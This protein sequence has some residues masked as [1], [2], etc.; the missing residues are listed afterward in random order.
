M[1]EVARQRTR[2]AAEL[3]RIPG[4]TPSVLRRVGSAI[5]SALDGSAP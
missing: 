4:I 2:G 5:L 1:L 3:G